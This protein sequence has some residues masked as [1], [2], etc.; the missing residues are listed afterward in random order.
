[1]GI[2]TRRA[3]TRSRTHIVSFSI[4]GFFGF[5]ALFVMAMFLSVGALVTNWLSGLPDYSSAN[6]YLVAEPTTVYA[7]DSSV[8]SEYYLQNRRSVDKS[9]ISDYVIKGIIATE[10]KR[11]YQHKGV[12]PQGIMRAVYVQ[13][14]GGSEG[15]STITQQLVRNT[16]LSNEQFESTLK[17]KVRE[18]YIAVQMEKM[19]NKDQILTMYLNTIY[20][21]HSAYGIEAASITYFNKE[22]KDLTLAQAA[23]LCGDRKAHV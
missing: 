3:R 2:R 10:D 19:Y 15:A 7:A 9:E 22:A 12:D 14:S 21:G 8:I 16:I 11:F 18:A 5:V 20:F 13:I 4:A 1:M 6:A 23:T 17:R